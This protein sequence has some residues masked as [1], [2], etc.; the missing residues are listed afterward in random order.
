M[1][2]G[3][4]FLFNFRK[5]TYLIAFNSTLFMGNTS[6]SLGAQMLSETEAV[7]L[8][9]NWYQ[10]GD[11]GLALCNEE[12]LIM[13]AN[14]KCAQLL[15][16]NADELAGQYLVEFLAEHELE[17]EEQKLKRFFQSRAKTT[18]VLLPFSSHKDNP[19]HLRV[20]L[21]K[22][23]VRAGTLAIIQENIPFLIELNQKLKRSNA[24]LQQFAFAAAHDLQQPL[25]TISSFAGLIQK[26]YSP[27]LDSQGVEYLNYIIGGVDRMS[28]LIN[29]IL[30][31]AQVDNSAMRFLRT[32][33]NLVIE[34]K[35]MDISLLLKEKN[36]Q[37][38]LRSLPSL[39]CVPSQL[40]IVFYNLI[41]NGIKFNQSE[42]PTIEISSQEGDQHWIFLVKDNG[43]GLEVQYK[44][45]IFELFQR[46]QP[47]E[48]EGTGLGLA[49]CKKI[50]QRHGGEIQ[51]ES[52]SS[53]G[54]VF[55]FTIRKNLNN[56][57]PSKDSG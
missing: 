29:N 54:S 43:I 47:L 34:E 31:Y 50:I 4:T 18:Q 2:P 38:I 6:D 33:I 44:E 25:R 39:H 53:E 12:G 48:Y 26:R 23:E 56:S 1:G 30:D 5:N 17:N 40:G 11:L 42:I 51:L 21:I 10:N 7:A 28:Q 15:D 49:L 16:Q 35:L 14:S 57:I 46:L 52:S 36:A 55:S 41:T 37:I 45:R 24:D 9:N 8:F 19:S 32:D 27:Q 22:S 20:Q 13:E 3:E